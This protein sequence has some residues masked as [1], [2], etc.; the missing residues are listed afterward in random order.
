MNIKLK[1]T[2]NWRKL[3]SVCQCPE[4]MPNIFD[5]RFEVPNRGRRMRDR[6]RSII[7][8]RNNHA[9][10]VWYDSKFAGMFVLYRM[11]TGVFETH[12]LLLKDFHGLV[13]VRIGRFAINQVM[14]LPYID[15]LTSYCPENL[16][17]TFLF[18]RM[19]GFRHVGEYPM[20]WIKNGVQYAMK[21]VEFTR[22]DLRH[23]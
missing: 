20:K 6:I 2:R 12:T 10:C 3:W 14:S 17:Q 21:A 9:F 8:N 5:D 7:A 1:E 11:A 13:A 23:S 15:K 22:N 16:P 4:V 18:A 19:C